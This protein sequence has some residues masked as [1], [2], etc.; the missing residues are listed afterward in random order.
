MLKQFSATPQKEPEP[1]VEEI[2]PQYVLRRN[3]DVWNIV[4]EGHELPPVR[5]LAGMTYIAELIK[6]KGM[7][8]SAADLYRIEHPPTGEALDAAHKDKDEIAMAY[9][10]G[11][12]LTKSMMLR[13]R[14][15]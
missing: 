6:A 10:T 9:G 2:L 8:I 1:S 13:P 3:G 14:R 12:G 4:F 7:P 15:P 5:H 11:G